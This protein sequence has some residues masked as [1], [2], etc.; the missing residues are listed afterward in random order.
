MGERPVV[1]VSNT[2]VQSHPQPSGAMPHE[3]R[4]C[5]HRQVVCETIPEG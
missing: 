5:P 4:L 3:P 1:R 2:P